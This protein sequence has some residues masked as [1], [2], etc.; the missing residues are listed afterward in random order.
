M[1]KKN[2]YSIIYELELIYFEHATS[3]VSRVDFLVNTRTFTR[4]KFFPI[5]LDPFMEGFVFQRSRQ[6]VINIVSLRKVI[7]N[8]MEVNPSYLL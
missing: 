8:N 1:R 4:S 2:L 7:E 6:E 5:S 3:N